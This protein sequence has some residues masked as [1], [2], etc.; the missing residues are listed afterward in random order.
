MLLTL[1][2]YISNYG[3][4]LLSLAQVFFYIGLLIAVLVPLLRGRPPGFGAPSFMMFV[5]ALFAP[6]ALLMGL[7]AVIQSMI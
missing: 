6:I 1:N 4:Q 7:S 3:V 5:L 2:R